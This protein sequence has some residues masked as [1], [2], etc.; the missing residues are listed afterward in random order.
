VVFRNT[1]LLGIPANGWRT[2]SRPVDNP[3]VL[4]IIHQRAIEFFPER[5]AQKY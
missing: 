5:L 1:A 4:A 2:D 3:A